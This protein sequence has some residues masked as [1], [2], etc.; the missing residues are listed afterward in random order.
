MSDPAEDLQV[1]IEAT[2]RES[3]DLRAAMGL[4]VVRLY[5]MSA[6]NDAP[7]PYIIIGEDQIIDDA[8]ECADSSEAYTTI[9]VWTRNDGDVAA[10]RRQAKAIARVLRPALKGL[11]DFSNFV[12]TLAEFKS[13][14]H[15]T[16]PDGLT[17]HSVVKH[18]FLLDPA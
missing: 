6:P 2:L 13:A 10:S 7:Y 18:R 8:T 11:A 3:E 16:D 5:T 1:A 9:H 12:V 14:F 15:Q 4:S 17:A